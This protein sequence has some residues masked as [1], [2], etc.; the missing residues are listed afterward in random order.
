[1]TCDSKGNEF[2]NTLDFIK[3]LIIV[4]LNSSAVR[5]CPGDTLVFT[6][7]TDTGAL[8]WGSDGTTQIAVF[9]EAD[10]LNST[11]NLG[12]FTLS[13]INITGNTSFVSTATVYNVS[14]EDDGT[15][16]ICSD[17]NNKIKTVEV[18][19]SGIT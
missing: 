2:Y 10:Q 5:V 6:C 16:I 19:I 18:R 15:I 1:M 11:E 9:F 4:S 14:I 13:Y 3:F 12:I 17:G 7:I 8:I